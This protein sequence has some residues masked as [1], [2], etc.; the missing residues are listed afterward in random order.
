MGS[1]VT[2]LKHFFAGPDL[3]FS[4]GRVWMTF[5]VLFGL[6]PTTPVVM[7]RLIVAVAI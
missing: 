1:A 6:T 7:P 4:R 3:A 5:G 2:G